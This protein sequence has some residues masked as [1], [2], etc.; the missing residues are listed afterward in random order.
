MAASPVPSTLPA[1]NLVGSREA[2]GASATIP[3]AQVEP[4][5]RA[6]IDHV[7]LEG[8][9]GQRLLDLGFLPGTEVVLRRRAPL[10]DPAE[11]ELRGTRLC[12]RRSETS[13]IHVR[14]LPRDPAG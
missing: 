14:L 9:L 1:R 5:A 4:N 12:L 2:R 6:V 7:A 3:L 11:Y 13:R 10:G 8:T